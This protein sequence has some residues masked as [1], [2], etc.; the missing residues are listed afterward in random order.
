R[1]QQGEPLA[2]VRV[3]G[4]QL[5]GID[6]PPERAPSMIDE[7]P[8]FAVAAAAAKGTTR[9]TGLAELKVKESDRLAAIA[10]GLR[11]CGAKVAEVADGLE[12]E[13]AN[14]ALPGGTTVDAAL[15]HRIAMA[16]L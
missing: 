16:F 3:R 2:D 8:I 10:R 1:E 4:A 12:I 13:G 11:A 5:H 14:G 9:M 7:Y 6:V 15:D